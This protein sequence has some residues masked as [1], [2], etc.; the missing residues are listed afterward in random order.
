MGI[1]FSVNDSTIV[2]DEAEQKIIDDFF[3]KWQYPKALMNVTYNVYLGY[4]DLMMM[5]NTTERWV[6][7]G[8]VT[9]PPCATSVYWNVLRTI[10]PIKQSVLDRFK[11][12][13]DERNPGLSKLGNWREIQPLTT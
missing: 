2:L 4:G 3:D 6:Y 10:Y 8:S 1:I 9:T 12:K 5:V 13:L 7:K 11:S